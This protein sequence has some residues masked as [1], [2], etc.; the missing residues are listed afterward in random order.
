MASINRSNLR[1]ILLSGMVPCLFFV[2]VIKVIPIQNTF[3]FDTDEGINLIKAVLY[4]E[5]FSLYT[6]IPNDQPPLFT[7]L[8][9]YWFRLFDQSIFA[10]RLLTLVFS[11]LLIWSFYQTL[12]I[13]L[14]YLLAFIGTLLLMMSSEFLQLSVSVMIGMPSLALAMLSIYLLTLYKQ[15]RN[16]YFLVGS[17]AVLALSFQVKLFTAFLIP[18]MILYLL[19]FRI[20]KR[21]IDEI[22]RYLFPSAFL[23]L[24]AILVI[25]LVIGFS[26]N[27][28][29]YEQLLQPHVSPAVKA[30]LK[31]YGDLRT[32]GS[33]L[34]RRDYV[35]TILGLLGI[36]T[37]VAKKQWDGLFPLAWLVTVSI[38]L[39]NHRPIWYHYYHLVSIPLAWLAAYG[40]AAVINFLK[41]KNELFYF[42]SS[43]TNTFFIYSFTRGI[44]LLGLLGFIYTKSLQ[45][46]SDKSK[47]K[48]QNYSHRIE[49]VNL[50]RKN[51]R[52]NRWLF[53]D[54]P[55]YAFYAGLQVPPEIAVFSLKQFVTGKLT[56]TDLLSVL[57]KYR[58]AQIF[59]RRF[60]KGIKNNNELMAYISKHYSIIYEDD[61]SSYYVLKP[62]SSPLIEK[63]P[64]T[65]HN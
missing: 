2:F 58:P 32:I 19:D 47:Y 53:T 35:L 54:R 55:I 57:H 37:V 16:L 20:Y 22:K 8:L 44:I 41:Q 13:Y 9:S 7:A 48:Q 5:G 6:E 62:R 4:S 43:E 51:T 49:I 52:A 24:G 63:L 64:A 56:Y 17:G 29:S 50:L 10:A 12:Y 11:T 40:A 38:L 26:F 46:N 23:W 31:N 3:E 21:D 28:I 15:N 14:G 25:Y 65:H 30:A 60:R 61:A 39:L 45:I 34:I 59:L 1:N 18:I 33:R 27:S 36:S 42:Q